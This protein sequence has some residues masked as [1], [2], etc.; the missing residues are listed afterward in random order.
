MTRGDEMETKDNNPSLVV[1]NFRPQKSKEIIFLSSRTQPL[2]LS[3]QILDMVLV[4]NTN[5]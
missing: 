5:N 3:S 1:T 4:G 2:F